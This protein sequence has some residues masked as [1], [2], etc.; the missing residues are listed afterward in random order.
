MARYGWLVGFAPSNW[1]LPYE[2]RLRRRH[3]EPNRQAAPVSKRATTDGS[4]TGT[5][6]NWKESGDEG[7]IEP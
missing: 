7:V 2:L 4:G 1:I 6:Y 3:A 5:P